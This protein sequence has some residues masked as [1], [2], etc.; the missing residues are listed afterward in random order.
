MYVLSYTVLNSSYTLF[1]SYETWSILALL[2]NTTFNLCI[3]VKVVFKCIWTA[4][5][6]A[7]LFQSTHNL[8][9]APP[10]IVY[11]HWVHQILELFSLTFYEAY[12]PNWLSNTLFDLW[13]VIKVHVYGRLGYF[14]QY[15]PVSSYV[16]VYISNVFSAILYHCLMMWCHGEAICVYMDWESPSQFKILTH[17][18]TWEW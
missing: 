2:S 16:E 3:A 15:M 11:V 12:G 7:S 6:R 10:S 17:V 1:A 4:F 9:T 14:L 18:C 5:C 13:F 8:T